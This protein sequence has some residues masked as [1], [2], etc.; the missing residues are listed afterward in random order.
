VLDEFES[1]DEQKQTHEVYCNP[2]SFI[3]DL[4]NKLTKKI[5]ICL[6]KNKFISL[7]LCDMTLFL[8]YPS[9]PASSDSTDSVI[10]LINYKVII[11]SY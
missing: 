3:Y 7:G 11:Y 2:V 4:I 9:G 5:Y 10:S 6:E 1:A 8:A